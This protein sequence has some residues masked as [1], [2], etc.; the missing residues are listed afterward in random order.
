MARVDSGRN[1]A[2]N[3]RPTES[4]ERGQGDLQTFSDTGTALSVAVINMAM[5]VCYKQRE[6]YIG[7]LQTIYA[8]A[9]F[10]H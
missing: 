2:I 10:D 1:V 8:S 7:V 3:S 5:V 4:G 6:G 9:A